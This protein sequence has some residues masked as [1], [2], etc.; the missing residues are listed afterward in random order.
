M[1]FGVIMLLLIITL[2][3]YIF[4]SAAKCRSQLVEKKYDHNQ[5]Y[6][7][8]ITLLYSKITIYIV[9]SWSISIMLHALMLKDSTTFEP[10]EFIRGGL[11]VIIGILAILAFLLFRNLVYNKYLTDNVVRVI[12]YEYSLSF[13]SGILYAFIVSYSIETIL[14][15]LYTTRGVI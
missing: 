15:M 5:N 10:N 2:T 8:S 12:A 3:L 6:H 9:I 7:K 14:F 4:F 1:I 13:I 11:F